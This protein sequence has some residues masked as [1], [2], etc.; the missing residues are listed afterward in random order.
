MPDTWTAGVD[1]ATGYV[2]T[3]SDW[4]ALLG[5]D[6]SLNFLGT[7][8]DHSGDSGDGGEV[9]PFIHGVETST[10]TVSVNENTW[11]T[12]ASVTIGGLL[13]Y[14]QVVILGHIAKFTAGD[15]G[16]AWTEAKG[17]IVRTAGAGG[18][19]VGG[20]E[21]GSTGVGTSFAWG[22]MFLAV[23]LAGADGEGAQTFALQAFHDTDVAGVARNVTA[24]I[25]A[26]RLR[27]AA[28]DI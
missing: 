27:K 4:N 25:V 7:T 9:G 15:G 16:A 28:T 10:A 12:I 21:S 13:E 18:I 3:A 14:D 20:A 22:G 6:G 11:T 23:Y 17:K 24:S 8:H 2:V 26:V 19:I 1:R 5:A